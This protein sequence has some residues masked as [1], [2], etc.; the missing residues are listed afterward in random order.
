VVVATAIAAEGGTD[1]FAIREAFLIG[2]LFGWHG[3]DC[4]F[5]VAPPAR[6]AAE[7]A[8]TLEPVIVGPEVKTEA[9]G[10]TAGRL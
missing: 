10:I 3:I 5:Q 4:I 1:Q 7:Y 9:Y 2:G 8:T 6:M